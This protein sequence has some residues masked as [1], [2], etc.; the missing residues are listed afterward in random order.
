MTNFEFE[1]AR[2]VEKACE[3]AKAANP[4]KA[5]D[6]S[7]VS[8]ETASSISNSSGLS[9]LKSQDLNEPSNSSRGEVELLSAE[10]QR[11]GRIRIESDWAGT[12]W[13]VATVAKLRGDEDGSVYF[14]E[15]IKFIVRLSASE[16]Q[17]LHGFKKQFG[18]TI[19]WQD[20]E[21]IEG[22]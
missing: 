16:R 18:G 2:E 5:H 9:C 20:N 14:P 3:A 7:K 15:E 17:L 13:L 10:Y 21:G 4:A 19:Q 8:G 6:P 22:Q 11:V 12:V 1:T